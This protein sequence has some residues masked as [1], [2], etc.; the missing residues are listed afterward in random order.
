MESL[1]IPPA[2]Y[3]APTY[4]AVD[5]A[6]RI[7]HLGYRWPTEFRAEDLDK[8]ALMKLWETCQPFVVRNAMP[9]MAPQ[10]FL[11]SAIGEKTCTASFLD[12]DQWVDSPSTLEDYFRSWQNGSNNALQVRVSVTSL[13]GWW[14]CD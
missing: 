5:E 10:A 2:R 4:S 13:I 9:L 6:E 3:I 7:S 12:D 8:E 14:L 11:S 1:D